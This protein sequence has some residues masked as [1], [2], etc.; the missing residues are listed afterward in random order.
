MPDNII[1]I[2]KRTYERISYQKDI[3]YVVGARAF[4]GKCM[5]IGKGGALIVNNSLFDIPVGNELIISIPFSKRSLSIKRK[6]TVRWIKDD[7]F[8]IRF[9]KRKN[10][11]KIY[12][13]KITILTNTM[14]FSAVINNLSKGGANI[15]VDNDSV[16]KKESEIHV[17]IPFATVE[18]ELTK[19]SIVRWI[20]KGQCGIQFF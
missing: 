11:R 2:N 18:K 19:R 14:I 17:V 8:G 10:P 13:R 20:G 6:S 4:H 16:L 15:F 3:I 1:S 9:Y 5:N 7:Q 12:K